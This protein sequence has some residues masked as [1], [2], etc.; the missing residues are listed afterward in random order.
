MTMYKKA[1]AAVLFIAFFASCTTIKFNRYTGERL[2]SFP[3]ELQGEY[4]M[5]HS[6][7]KKSDSVHE[8]KVSIQ[9]SD[10]KILNK[11]DSVLETLLHLD[12]NMVLT[13]SGKFY[14]LNSP[15]NVS[16]D[17]TAWEI[18]PLITEKG[19]IHLWYL[20]PGQYSKSIRK[21]FTP[22]PQ[23]DLT[24]KMNDANFMKWC[25]KKLKKGHSH[26]LTKWNNTNP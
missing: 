17:F 20:N 12:S 6:A 7:G 9:K 14:F 22:A 19:H 5:P 24:Y 13:K 26:K 21:K 1:L 3:E 16:N 10:V 15:I 2:S 11:K 25:K 18:V 8:Y 4:F 23:L